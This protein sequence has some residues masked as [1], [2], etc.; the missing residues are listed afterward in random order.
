LL[1]VI[2]PRTFIIFLCANKIT[3][4]KKSMK[5]DWSD[6]YF[7][8]KIRLAQ[9]SRIK[10]LKED[11]E[12]TVMLE[13]A[14]Y[15]EAIAVYVREKLYNKNIVPILK[16]FRETGGRIKDL[17]DNTEQICKRFEKDMQKYIINAQ[18]DFQKSLSAQITR[19][20]GREFSAPF[21][22]LDDKRQ[23]FG[24]SS[25]DSVGHSMAQGI[26]DVISIAVTTAVA[27]S[28]A[29]ISGGFGSKVGVAIMVVLLHTT[30]PIGW[31]IGAVAGALLGGGVSFLARDSITDV[32]KSRNLP[33]FV[34]K[35]LLTE[36]KLMKQIEEGRQRIYDTV[37]KEIEKE[38]QSLSYKVSGQ[39]IS[40]I[41]K[42]LNLNK[43]SMLTD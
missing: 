11:I 22:T 35:N 21:L 10:K 14:K 3:R 29:T 4:E 36:A 8:T 18:D 30:G 9:E 38:I 23:V 39:I 27:G 40:E 7:Q 34:T 17:E 1:Y 41:I 5:I 26:T 43:Y 28:I 12:H 20:V 32:V 33:P 2:I 6:D 19:V 37:K 25:A 15:S 24:T 42:A 31:I 13:F 16:E